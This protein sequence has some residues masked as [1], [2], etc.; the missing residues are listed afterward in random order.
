[1]TRSE[2]TDADNCVGCCDSIACAPMRSRSVFLASWLPACM[3]AFG[4]CGG[5]GGGTNQPPI[6]NVPSSNEP[7]PKDDSSERPRAPQA[8]PSVAT[9]GGA[10]CEEAVDRYAR[11]Y[12]G[13]TEASDAGLR[14]TA[15]G[16]VL[17]RGAYLT[18]C[19]VPNTSSVAICAAIQN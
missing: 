6:L 18:D 4:S 5:S 10:S 16:A 2:S 7:T 19:A 8:A 14:A 9:G 11:E 17:N 13:G 1:M 3:L 12:D 15:Y